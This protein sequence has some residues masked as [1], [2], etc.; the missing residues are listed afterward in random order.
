MAV[1]N[2]FWAATVAASRKCKAATA[3]PCERT[4]NQ[5][6]RRTLKLLTQTVH[7]ELL[8]RNEPMY[9]A[10]KFFAVKNRVK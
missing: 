5:V 8:L 7:Q 9:I 6:K 1:L 4:Y 3:A 10:S 2:P